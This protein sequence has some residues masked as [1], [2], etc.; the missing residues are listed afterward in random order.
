MDM[1]RA[2]SIT[3]PTTQRIARKSFLKLTLVADWISFP[4]VD[5]APASDRVYP[6]V[7]SPVFAEEDGSV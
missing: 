4:K 5:V 6:C 1:V 7:F 2:C 3:T